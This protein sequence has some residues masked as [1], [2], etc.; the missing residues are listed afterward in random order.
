LEQLVLPNFEGGMLHKDWIPHQVCEFAGLVTVWV[1]RLSDTAKQAAFGWEPAE[2]SAA[3]R[4]FNEF[5]AAQEGGGQDRRE[6]HY[7]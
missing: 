5:L 6:A 2:C 3:V 4:V 1:G 7:P